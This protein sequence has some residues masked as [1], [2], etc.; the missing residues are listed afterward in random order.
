MTLPNAQKA[1]PLHFW[2][3]A[4]GFAGNILEWY[5]F[6]VYAGKL[7]DR[8]GRKPMLVSVLSGSGTAAVLSFKFKWL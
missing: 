6:T 7:S 8:V 4:A 5:D 3:L 1:S 2:F